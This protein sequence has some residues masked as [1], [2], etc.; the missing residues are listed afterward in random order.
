MT[1]KG[2]PKCRDI[3]L[4]GVEYGR[5]VFK[6]IFFPRIRIAIHQTRHYKIY[7]LNDFKFPSFFLLTIWHAKFSLISM[8]RYPREMIVILVITVFFFLYRF[9]SKITLLL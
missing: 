2:L 6:Y 7:S 4:R 8:K 1:S 5:N 9:V 3:Y